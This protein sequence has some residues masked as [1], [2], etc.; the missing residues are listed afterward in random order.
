[1]PRTNVPVPGVVAGVAGGGNDRIPWK[2]ITAPDLSA[3]FWGGDG[4]I[5]RT[6]ATVPD[7]FVDFEGVEA[8][9]RCQEKTYRCLACWQVCRY[10]RC[11]RYSIVPA[12]GLL[13]GVRG[14]AYSFVACLSHL[15]LTTHHARFL[16]LIE[17]WLDAKK[18][19][20][21]GLLSSVPIQ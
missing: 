13:A 19:C 20:N 16:L 10:S 1:M 7:R 6:N 5:P 11:S 14:G 3:G 2:S 15:T 9:A 4:P 8:M 21:N 17:T 18:K 12:P